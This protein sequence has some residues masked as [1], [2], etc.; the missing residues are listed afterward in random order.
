M[1]KLSRSRSYYLI[2]TFVLILFS[3]GSLFAQN[4]DFEKLEEKTQ[5]FTVI[6]DLKIEMA[7]GVHTSEQTDRLLGTIVDEN[8]LI[9][10]DG[11]ALL[12]DQSIPGL[13]GMSV[14]IT[15]IRIDVTTMDGQEYQ[16]DYIGSDRFTK[17]GFAR[18]RGE[19]KSFE[20]VEFQSENNIKPGDWLAL[21]MLLPE[22]ITPPLAADIGMVSTVITSPEH[23]PLTVGFN[24]TQKA[25]VLFNEELKPIGILG[26]LVDPG[27]ATTDSN[28]MLESF[29][30]FRMPLLGLLSVKRLQELIADPPKKGATDR[31]WLGISLQALTDE[32]S[33]FW[34]L[35]VPGGIIVN[36]I[37]KGSPAEKAGL[38][39]GDVIYAINGD[40]LEVNKDEKISLFQRVVVELGPGA[41]LELSVLRP[42]G[43]SWKELSLSALLEAAPL[44]AS[45]APD[46]DIDGLEFKVRSLV[47]S[48]FMRLNQEPDNFTGVVVSEIKLGGPAEVGGLRI[49]DVIQ[50][51]GDTETRSLEDMIETMN[52]VELEKPSEVILFVWRQNKT[53][54]INLKSAWN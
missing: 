34:G 33:D 1:N 26:A 16:A 3:A 39:V 41:D 25:A 6:V 45:D 24:A 31:A 52:R 38:E 43:S 40:T 4:F 15:P 11:T 36:D 47:F 49:G 12:G 21:Y 27:N 53:M 20:F 48:D 18:I 17:L 54:F 7:F 51:V 13:S 30:Q 5:R 32:L 46:Y 23:F 37:V 10:F 42:E 44:A 2:A 35:H 22:F 28:G 14:K 50:K 9:I 19:G 29:G 8:G